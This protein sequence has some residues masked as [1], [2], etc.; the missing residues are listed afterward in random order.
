MKLFDAEIIS[1]QRRQEREENKKNSLRPLRLG[2]KN[3]SQDVRIE[4]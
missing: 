2:G 1:P 4:F 3:M